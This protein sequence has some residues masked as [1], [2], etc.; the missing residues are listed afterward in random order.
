[1][2]E[3]RR[4]FQVASLF[5]FWSGQILFL[6]GRR[7][8]VSKE[9][10]A[11]LFLKL[12]FALSILKQTRAEEEDRVLLREMTFSRSSMSPPSQVRPCILLCG[13]RGSEQCQ[14]LIKTSF[15]CLLLSR[16]GHHRP[17]GVCSLECGGAV[18]LSGRASSVLVTRGPGTAPTEFL[19]PLG[20]IRV[21]WRLVHTHTLPGHCAW[22]F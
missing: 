2:D 12:E 8:L 9:R 11:W 19:L 3:T 21:T 6:G 1:M 15:V 7:D 17:C 13:P 10:R 4:A 20:S 5:L 18:G 14:T 22:S 16:N